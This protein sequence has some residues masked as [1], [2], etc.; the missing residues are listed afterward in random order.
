M[1]IAEYKDAHNFFLRNT[2][3]EARFFSLY[4]RSVDQP[5]SREST[6]LDEVLFCKLSLYIIVGIVLCMYKACLLF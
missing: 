2:C 3:F 5:F 6:L 4:A 1:F